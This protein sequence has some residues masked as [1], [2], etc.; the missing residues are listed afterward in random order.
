VS[1][2]PGKEL[3]SVRS[4]E[5]GCVRNVLH[6]SKEWRWIKRELE[7]WSDYP[8]AGL[9]NGVGTE[10]SMSGSQQICV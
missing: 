2:L 9:R 10:T 8:Q 4:A 5:D 6:V 7:G 3:L 1:S